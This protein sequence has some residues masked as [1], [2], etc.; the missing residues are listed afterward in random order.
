[1]ER[2]FPE[3]TRAFPQRVQLRIGSRN[4]S[5]PSSPEV[6]A[7]LQLL[8]GSERA[9]CQARPNLPEASAVANRIGPDH[10]SRARELTEAISIVSSLPF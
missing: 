3:R 7:A 8:I 6:T 1:L 5:R 4:R 2:P 9:A 10:V